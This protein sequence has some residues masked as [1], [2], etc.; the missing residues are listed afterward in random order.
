M[1]KFF[2]FATVALVL[3]S[4]DKD[5]PM[6]DSSFAIKATGAD[7]NDQCAKPVVTVSG[8]ITSFTEWTSDKIWEIEG[9]V[10]VKNATL[11]IQPGTYIKAKPLATGV[12]TGVLV[13]TKTGTI[14]AVGTPENPIVFT[15]YRL[16]D[17]QASPAPQPGDFGGVVFLGDAPVNTGSVTNIIEGLG[18]QPN[19]ADFQF[20][21]SNASHDVGNFQY[22][23]IEYAGRK[24]TPDVEINGLTFGGV[25]NAGLSAANTKIHHIQVSFGSDDSYEWFGG[26]VN[27]LNLVSFAPEDDNFD[28][29]WG[30]TGSINFALALADKN[31]THSL[32]G[33]NP[34]SNGVELDND[35]ASSGNL[36]ITRPTINH[37]S[38]IGV[39]STDAGFYENGIHVRRNGRIALLN[40]TVSGY[41][42]A[43][44][45]N[46]YAIF[47]EG[48]STGTFSNVGVNSWRTSPFTSPS[49]ITNV[50]EVAGANF[51]MAQPFFNLPSPDFTGAT[52]GAFVNGTAW[53]SSWTKFNNF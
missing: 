17:C 42:V 35:A 23:R 20:G 45:P 52:N 34:D 6:A 18:D 3:S 16:L 2:L 5:E 26:T 41:G 47:L 21:G 51:G 48:T 10:R 13:I 37:L 22:V 30:Y 46:R 19:S 8:D 38:V 12:A 27:A 32:S 11:K 43:A 15:S 29:D 39:P 7:Y 53:I 14:D 4:C 44:A 33:G 50:T 40:S 24:L 31:S 28:F 25:G 9:V 1:K 49:P 36:P